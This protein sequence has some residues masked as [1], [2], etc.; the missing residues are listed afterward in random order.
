MYMEQAL[1]GQPLP[2]RPRQSASRSPTPYCLPPGCQGGGFQIRARMM[3]LAGQCQ[4][5]DECFRAGLAKLLEE[6][7]GGKYPWNAGDAV[8]SRT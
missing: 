3:A 4:G 8:G 2:K 7:K 5:D 6:I 1:A